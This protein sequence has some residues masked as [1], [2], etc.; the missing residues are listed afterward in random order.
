MSGPM[1][2]EPGGTEQ[3]TLAL[4]LADTRRRVPRRLPAD[5]TLTLRLPGFGPNEEEVSR[6][7]AELADRV[8][9]AVHPYEV[10]AL[11]EADGL[12]ADMIRQ[13]YGHPNI[14]S[15]AAALY[16]RVPRV[17]PEPAA[18][19]DPWRPDHVRCLLRGVLFA[20][21]GLAYL[22]TA[23][24]WHPGRHAAALIVAGVISWAWGQALGHRAY[25]R[26]V[27]GQREAGRTLLVGAP[28]GAA[29]ATAGAALAAWGGAVTWA[30]AAQSLYLAAA[31][32]LLVLGRE[33]LLLA[34]LTPLIAG[35]AVLPWWEPGPLLR[36][37]LPALAL[38][39][40]LAAAGRA[41]RAAHTAPAAAGEA[42]ARPPLRRSLPYGLFGLAAAVLVLLEG[43]QAPYAV[44][45]LTVSMG[46]AEWLLYRFRGLSVTALG[47][48]ATPLG[49]LLRSA[50]VLGLCLFS[51]VLLLLPVALL[52]GAA[53]AALLLVAATLWS[54]LLLQA[55]GVGWPPAVVCL[56][57][58]AVAGLVTFLAPIRGPLILPLCCGAAALCLAGCALWVLGRP[59]R[60][61]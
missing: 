4:R 3:D 25:L 11:L 36:T 40:T 59:A 39:A 19:P 20:L 22:L 31:G 42:G 18:T 61:A 10:A 1:A 54:A 8:G 12:S 13:R 34:A 47:A 29:A 52:T 43:R 51:Y 46:P 2:L 9:P 44:I 48:A 33:R 49:F 38:A 23:P 5:A 26:M 50:G 24:L 7:A 45:A 14:F 60:H 27:A 32:V 15:L 37:G 28:A 41:L 58:A 16:E 21:P 35:A 17:F 53:P 30:A 6:L 57:A 55:F 56:T